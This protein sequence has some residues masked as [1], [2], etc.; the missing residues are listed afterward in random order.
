MEKGKRKRRR[1]RLWFAAEN[2][3]CPEDHQKGGKPGADQLPQQDRSLR[4][5][6]YP[7]SEGASRRAGVTSATAILTP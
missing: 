1:P 4:P 7:G 5:R 3:F 6:G 2:A